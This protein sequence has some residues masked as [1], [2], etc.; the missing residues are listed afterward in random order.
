MHK[1]FAQIL[2][3]KKF[4]PIT[5]CHAINYVSALLRHTER[6]YFISGKTTFAIEQPRSNFYLPVMIVACPCQ[7][8]KRKVT[9]Q[10]IETS[11]LYQLYLSESA[12]VM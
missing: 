10:T 1:I 11:K 7:A 4:A 9:P 8:G 2:K 6:C 12:A 5:F 3:L